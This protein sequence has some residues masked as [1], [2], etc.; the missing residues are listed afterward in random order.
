MRP[1]M[2]YTLNEYDPNKP[3]HPMT[4][5][6]DDTQSQVTTSSFLILHLIDIDGI[7]WRVCFNSEFIFLHSFQLK[8]CGLKYTKDGAE[9][10]W[11]A[12]LRNTKVNSGDADKKV[13]FFLRISNCLIQKL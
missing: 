13:K 2:L 1:E 8:C 12:W 6:W 9:K 7:I 10:P 3:D 5:A 4:K 11:E